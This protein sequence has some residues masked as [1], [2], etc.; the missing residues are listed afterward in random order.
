M[1]SFDWKVVFGRHTF[2]SWA[3]LLADRTSKALA[4]PM[5]AGAGKLKSLKLL[6]SHEWKKRTVREVKAREL[7]GIIKEVLQYIATK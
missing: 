5:L 4:K 6:A 7:P 2:A 3:R 1:R